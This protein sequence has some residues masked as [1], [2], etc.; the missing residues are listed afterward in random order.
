MR[1]INNVKVGDEV[2]AIG[3]DTG[4]GD[5]NIG[6]ILKVVDGDDFNSYIEDGNIE[7]TALTTSMFAEGNKKLFVL[8][9]DFQRPRFGILGENPSEQV[10][11]REY[12]E[13]LL[14]PLDNGVYVS[15]TVNSDDALTD[16]QQNY[17]QR[18]AENLS[19]SLGVARPILETRKIGKDQM[20]MV[21][22]GFP[23]ALRHLAQIMTWAEQEKQ[24]KL[25]D[26]RNLPNADVEFP[27][28]EYRHANDNSIQKAEGLSALERV[29]HESGKLHIGH[30]IFNALCEL[31]LVLRG[32]I[33]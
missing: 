31:E 23:L 7:I 32:D 8:L 27:S 10:F 22:D 13:N 9:E 14:K 26:W 29:D 5:Y 33:K 17:A 3:V 11:S 12:H 1:D 2:L 15:V 16:A 19:E 24:Y 6:D 21:N 20:H 4:I 28:A 25:H 18:V 30:K